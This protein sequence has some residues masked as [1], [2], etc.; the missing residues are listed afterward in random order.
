MKNLVLSVAALSV[1]LYTSCAEKEAKRIDMNQVAQFED[2]TSHIIPG[3]QSIHT[4]QLEDPT[5]FKLIVGSPSFYTADADKKQAAAIRTG[6][7]VLHVLGPDNSIKNATLVLTK[8]DN[9]NQEKRIPADG[10]SLDMKIDSL[11]KILYPAK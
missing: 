2:S 7:M 3:T 4:L 11:K 9:D 5:E 6:L 10:I 1:L 8:K